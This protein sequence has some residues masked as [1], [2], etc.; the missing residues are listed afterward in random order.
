MKKLFTWIIILAVIAAGI[1]GA[2]WWR[3]RQTQSQ[4]ATA[5][6]L[7]TGKVTRGELSITVPASGNIAVNEKANLSFK[8]PG[9]V[10]YVS[11]ELSDRVTAGQEL[12]QL[13]TTGLE[14]AVR[15]AEISL[16]QARVNLASLQKPASEEDIHLAELAIQN[17]A[18]SLEVARISKEAAEAQ[19][20]LSIRT[21]QDM[22]DK[23]EDAYEGTID[24]LD[25]MGLPLSY[26][27][28]VTAAYMEAEGNVGITQVKAEYQIQQIQSQWLSA[29]Q[30]Y[31]QAQQN[32]EDLQ[33]GPDADNIRQTELQI[34][35]AQLSLDQAKERL[36]NTTLIAPFDGIVAAVNIQVGV[37]AP[38][39]L[40]AITLLDTSELYIEVNVDEI[41][42]GKVA[43]GQPVSITLDAY[44]ETTLR[45]TVERIAATPTNASGIITYQVRVKLAGTDDLLVLDGMTVSVLIQT[46]VVS[47]VLLV[48][49]WA[50]R[51]DQESGETY[52]YR[53]VD[54]V[55][56]RTPI[57][58]G[59]R[60]DTH[61]IITSGLSEG[62]TVA[63]V[64]ET[65]SLLDM[66][67]P[68]SMGR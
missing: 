40:P 42:I 32:L 22:A 61:T 26:G 46:D 63:L 38:T 48:P 21:A 37:A 27:A 41:D 49:N 13:D 53:I 10:T 36:T 31:R 55:P 47:D 3:N 60:S 6:I 59:E 39:G 35:Q 8:L 67:G 50:V 43:V 7:R 28:G 18:Q 17:A 34:E 19:G 66:Q 64:A 2:L 65:R 9:D 23:M 5:D 45:G 15:Q 12:A 58:T 56:V 51:T 44:P 62:A 57:V 52:V 33:T 30:S 14:R 11:V 54:G 20:S 24:R 16:E 1:G 29:Y 25:Q 68:P 4:S